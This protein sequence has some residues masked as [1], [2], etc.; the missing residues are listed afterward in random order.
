MTWQRINGSAKKVVVASGGRPLIITKRHS[1]Y[2]PDEYC[3]KTNAPETDSTQTNTSPN[4]MMKQEA[5]KS[6]KPIQ[7][8]RRP[9]KANDISA[10]ADGSIWAIGVNEVT[11]GYGIWKRF[12]TIWKQV[13]AV[14]EKTWV[15]AVRIAVS[16]QGAAYFVRDN[17]AIGYFTLDAEPKLVRLPGRG[18]DISIGGDGSIFVIGGKPVNGGWGVWRWN[19]D[20]N[21]WV[22]FNG[23]GGTSIA[24][25][26]QGNP[27]VIDDK[28]N[29]YKWSTGAWSK[30]R[31]SASSIA[32]G[33]EG[34]VITL[35][36]RKTQG[37]FRV[38]KWDHE[39]T[40]WHFIASGAT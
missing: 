14:N 3:Y 39:T 7:S 24:V 15:G 23:L 11:G 31:G 2:W 8:V 16:P 6:T 21:K 4:S 9:G 30:V 10:G 26:P 35:G 5:C 28:N 33:P 13:T 19:A 18:K 37:G 22:K 17:G 34:S 36:V 32:I 40:R 20:N 1:I 29:I 25:D 12:G 27:W 38:F